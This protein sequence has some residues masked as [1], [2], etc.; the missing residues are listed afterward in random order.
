MG[1]TDESIRRMHDCPHELLYK[2][3][4]TLLFSSFTHLSYIRYLTALP[5]FKNFLLYSIEVTYFIQKKP[6]S[7]EISFRCRLFSV[8]YVRMIDFRHHVIVITEMFMHRL[9]H[10]CEQF[11]V[12][13][14][15][16]EWRENVKNEVRM[17]PATHHSEIVNGQIFINCLDQRYHS[18]F[19]LTHMAYE[20][21]SCPLITSHISD[22]RRIVS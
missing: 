14:A 6:A 7:Q 18:C 10:F 4:S 3:K 5:G 2:L 11:L 13:Q 12:R 17:R 20:R 16:S 9:E 22:R 21:A 1:Y 19:R 15:E 8:L